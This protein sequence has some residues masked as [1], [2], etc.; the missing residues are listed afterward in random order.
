MAF[1]AFKE[2]GVQAVIV[3]SAARILD[4]NTVNLG[5]SVLFCEPMPYTAVEGSEVENLF[6]SRNYSRYHG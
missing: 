1:I 3:K 6:K 2:T 4:C 5:L